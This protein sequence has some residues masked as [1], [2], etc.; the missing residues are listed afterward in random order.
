MLQF[1]PAFQTI[2]HTFTAQTDL[3]VKQNRFTA[4]SAYVNAYKQ[5]KRAPRGLLAR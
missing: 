1:V 5:E 3:L 4:H 2:S